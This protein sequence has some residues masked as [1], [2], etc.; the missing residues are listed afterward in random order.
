MFELLSSP[1]LYYVKYTEEKTVLN[2]LKF[3]SKVDQGQKLPESRSRLLT[4][5]MV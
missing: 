1:E 5:R 4:L 2:V 3:F